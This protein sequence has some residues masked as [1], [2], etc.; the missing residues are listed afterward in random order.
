MFFVLSK[1]AAFLL[2][3]SNLLL[4][5][6]AIGVVLMAT[7]FRRTG[8]GLASA[9]F[10]LLAVAGFS[11]LGA[12]LLHELEVRFPPWDASRGAPDG[13]VILGGAISPNLSRIYGDTVV[14]GHAGRILAIGKLARAYPNARIV[15]SGG[16][17]NL[18]A[19]GEAE[20]SALPPLLDSLGV[21]R[22]RVIMEGRSRNTEENAVFT[23]DLVKPKPGERW[24]VVTSA[25]HMPRA[26]GCFRR[27][28]FAVEAY[29]VSWRTGK[30]VSLGPSVVFGYG[31]AATDFAAHEWI[32]LVAY[33]I[34]GRTNELLPR[35]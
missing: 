18:S 29:P 17:A 24:L 6:G 1:T 7:R 33:W 13:I 14:N 10:V 20:T 2:M 22:D 5:L 9:S 19:G 23:K 30:Q 4:L 12:L 28:G 35:S 16:D 8:I 26:I 3:P 25:W 15:Y 34:T 32:G 27:I 21:P 31:L 11:S